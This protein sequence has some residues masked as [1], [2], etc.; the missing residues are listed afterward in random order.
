[1]NQGRLCATLTCVALVVMQ[2]IFASDVPDG[3][4][5][6]GS[7]P[8]EYEAG[9]TLSQAYSRAG[10]GYLKS[11]SAE[12]TGFGTL[13]QEIDA[14]NYRG[15]RV[16][17]TAII[18]AVEVGDWAGM[19]M[20]VDG[21]SRRGVSFDNMSDRPIGGTVDWRPY[22]IVLD[23]PGDSEVIAF[24]VLLNGTGEVFLDDVCVESIGEAQRARP[25]LPLEPTNLGFEE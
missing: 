9:V 14:F 21:P 11:N 19:W 13:M 12:P 1:M 25:T 8:E 23:V 24:G 6:L 7:A 16:R 4:S 22:E 18:K 2:P 3:W 20:R 5:L 10:S 17:L 15:T